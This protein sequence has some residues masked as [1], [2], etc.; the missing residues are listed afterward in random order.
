MQR[1]GR[2]RAWQYSH[3]YC[4][5]VSPIYSHPVFHAPGIPTKGDE[6]KT[7]IQPVGYLEGLNWFSANSLQAFGK[8]GSWARVFPKRYTVERGRQSWWWSLHFRA[9]TVDPFAREVYDRVSMWD[10]HR[11]L[12]P[13]PRSSGRWR[14]GAGEARETGSLE[15]SV[16][17]FEHSLQKHRAR[18]QQNYGSWEEWNRKKPNIMTPGQHAD[19]DDEGEPLAFGLGK[20]DVLVLCDP[21]I[22]KGH[23][24]AFVGGAAEEDHR[25]A[26]DVAWAEGAIR[27]PGRRGRSGGPSQCTK[28]K[29]VSRPDCPYSAESVGLY[30]SFSSPYTCPAAHHPGALMKELVQ[31]FSPLLA[32]RIRQSPV[33]WGVKQDV[34]VLTAQFER[35]D[36]AFRICQIYEH[37]PAPIC[38]AIHGGGL[39]FWRPALAKVVEFKE[40][41]DA[42]SLSGLL[43][44]AFLGRA[45]IATTKDIIDPVP[46]ETTYG[47]WF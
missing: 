23:R 40:H 20:N 31:T 25:G 44:R 21:E 47:N 19:V 6:Q 24:Q 42:W 27:S 29:K 33:F 26:G 12:P 10:K 7:T 5:A 18:V 35:D 38:H 36:D 32:L 16:D 37:F 28:G 1:V 17:D 2:G 15:E 46:E 45:G 13:V 4:F 11:V 41:T 43:T 39:P 14:G 9:R 3:S 8:R 30:A 22:G 34:H